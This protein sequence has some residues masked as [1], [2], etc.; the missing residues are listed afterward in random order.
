MSEL[1]SG[2]ERRRFFG[3]VEAQPNAHGI[4]WLTVASNLGFTPIF[5]TRDAARY[6]RLRTFERVIS[7]SGTIVL[8]AETASPESLLRA[9]EP[10]ASSGGLAGLFSQSDYYVPVTAVI[11]RELGLPTPAPGAAFAARDKILMREVCSAAGVPCPRWVHAE[12]LDAALDAISEVGL[13]CV[14]KPPMGAASSNVVLCESA[15]DVRRHFAAIASPPHDRRGRPRRPG[16]LVEQY[17]CGY[18]VSVD[19]VRNGAE[20]VVL[21]VSDKR[22]SPHPYFAEIGD[23]FPSAL[24]AAVTEQ[25]TSAAIDALEALKLD[26]GA[27]HIEIRM[28]A[29]GPRL[30]EVNPRLGGDNIPDLMQHSLGVDVR[31]QLVALHAG[32]DPDFSPRRQGG[33]ATSWFT[34]PTAGTLVAIEGVQSALACPGVVEIHLDVEPGDYVSPAVS[35]RELY[36]YVLAVADSSVE[37][38]RRAETAYNHVR[39]VVDPGPAPR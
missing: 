20:T 6:G 22:L 37:A 14:L 38:V 5:L 36:G 29:D 4:H 1:T 2:K 31:S 28:T 39:L 19:L 33:A 3:I 13:P 8:T 30:I 27:A 32:F 17:L 26:F 24:P 11:A 7:E 10:Y 9:V 16:V 12:S 34:V 23:A 35:D 21:G 25:L 18:E 15:G